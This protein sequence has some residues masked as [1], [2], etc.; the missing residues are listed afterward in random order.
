M[1]S[2]SMFTCTAQL[3][4]MHVDSQMIVAFGDNDEERKG[5]G[6]GGGGNCEERGEEGTVGRDPLRGVKR[7]EG[8][9]MISAASLTSTEKTQCLLHFTS[10]LE[11]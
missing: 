5:G 8:D 1:M 10:C 11:A 2:M 7:P 6:R 3:N 4:S 9:Y